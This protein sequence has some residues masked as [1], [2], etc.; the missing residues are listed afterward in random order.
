MIEADVMMDTESLGVSPGCVVLQVGLVFMS[1]GAV[2]DRYSWVLDVQSQLDM[3]LVI[4]ADTLFWWTGQPGDACSRMFGLC[5]SDK[6][7][8]PSSVCLHVINAMNGYRVLRIWANG[9]GHDLPIMSELFRRCILKKPWEHKQERCYR[10]VLAQY[11]DTP[12]VMAVQRS[13]P[14]HDAAADADYQARSLLAIGK[15]YPEVWR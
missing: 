6:R 4:E 13:G 9:A 11:R 8:L 1:R 2:V 15:L 12:E 7:L 10:T 5:A 3:G 14:A